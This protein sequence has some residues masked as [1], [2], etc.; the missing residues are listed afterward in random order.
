MR[1]PAAPYQVGQLGIGL[2]FLLV[3]LPLMLLRPQADGLALQGAEQAIPPVCGIQR[4]TGNPCPTCGLTR[5]LVAAGQ[6]RFD[7]A[8]QLHVAAVPLFG[9]IALQLVLRPLL[10]F[11]PLRRR[12]ALHASAVDFL[13]HF[14]LVVWVLFLPIR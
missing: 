11:L 7:R 13:A 9:L 3:L 12:R 10:A 2:A 4:A 8:E 6:L 5:G 14:G 1:L